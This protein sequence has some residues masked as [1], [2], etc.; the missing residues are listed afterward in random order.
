LDEIQNFLAPHGNV[1]NV[2]MRRLTKERTF[3]GSIFATFDTREI[4]E[5]FV[6]DE[7]SMTYKDKPLTKML[8]DEYWTAKVKASKEKRQA[9]KQAKLTKKL[10]QIAEQ[11]KQKLIAKYVKGAVLEVSGLD[12]K[13]TKYEDLKTFFKTFG[14]VAFCAYEA[15][16]E[17][18]CCQNYYI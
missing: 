9:E 1:Q 6:K 5:K 2:V 8:Q 4:A 12:P 18:V 7:S 16:D 11:S 15:G 17:T 10:E 14:P 3:K 13:E